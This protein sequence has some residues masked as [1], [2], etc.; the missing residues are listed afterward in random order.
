MADPLATRDP[1][2]LVPDTS[3]VIAQLFVPGHALAGEREGRASAVV[4][5]VL[6]LDDG[7]VS[8]T[9]AAIVERFGDRHRDLAVTFRHHADRIANRLVPGTELSA[10]RRLL[11][12]ATFTHEYSVAAAGLCNPSAVAAPD[13]TGLRPGELRFVMSVRQIGEGHR[14]SIGFR[15]GM[16]DERGA[17]TIDEPG[18]FSTPGMVE[19]GTIAADTFRRL[20]RTGDTESIGWVLDGLGEQFTS[21]ELD[22]RLTE[23][24]TQNDTRR[25]AGETALRLRE[26]A[27]CSY[28]VTFPAST[29]LGERVLVPATSAE[30][31]GI[32]D[33]RFVHFVDDD[34][35]ATYYA[36]YT[37]FNGTGVSQ[38]LLATTDF[39]SFSSSPLL[40]AAA[41]N[42][43]VALFPRKIDGQF[44]ALSRH[45]GETNAVAYSDDIRLWRDPK[46]L[47]VP[48][49]A[50]EAI[51]VGNCGSP[52][53]TA[54]GWLV[55]THGVG[56][57]RSYS[58]GAFLLDI[59]DPTRV[60]G[61]TEQPLLTPQPDEQD[62]YV[63]NV[64]YSCGAVL[65]QDTLLVPFGIGDFNIGFATIAIDQLLGEMVH[66]GVRPALTPTTATER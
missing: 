4:E 31:N 41:E 16:I 20:A 15:T 19:H 50:W 60:I 27:A 63:P 46:T 11:L 57:M 22:A 51:Q 8:A 23:L 36:T 3:R 35:T 58:I 61:R 62:G 33:A 25:D 45:D 64:V 24:A 42:K 48:T 56:A 1:L 37:A 52:I 29:T 2:R 21:R 43:G 17:V 34:G 30:S 55:L 44:V 59:D 65:H 49:A 13:Q 28:E 32:E 5:H 7:Q 53:E 12:G 38:Q 54:E 18:P 40:G 47:A 10:E 39:L 9:L 14:S 26:F 66:D 6:G